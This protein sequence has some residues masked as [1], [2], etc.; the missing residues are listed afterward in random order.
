MSSN[1][2][3][4]GLDFLPVVTNADPFSGG[5][6]GA[7]GLYHVEG[8]PIASIFGKV[9]RTAE[10]EN[11]VGSRVINVTCDGGVGTGSFQRPGGPS[12][13]CDEAPG[14]YLGKGQPSLMVNLSQSWNILQN[15]RA[16]VNIDGMFGHAMSADY[17]AAS[18]TRWT[19]SFV[20]QD[21][22][23]MVAYTS[24]ERTTPVFHKNGFV[25]LR[26]LSLRY[27]LPVGLAGSLG[28]N[29]ASISGLWYNPATLWWEAGETLTERRPHDPEMM[30]PEMNF[31]GV[32]MGS[33]PPLSHFT[34]KVDVAF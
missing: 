3:E 22:P 2:D 28:L 21:D 12:V 29:R 32:N 31:P 16:G 34:V 30:S 15:V 17:L 8:F 25:K 24:V 26:E 4:L 7:R 13:P 20:Y 18:Q 19:R 33:P 14:I 27:S 23:I 10:F 1:I 11:G 9:I 6:E 5:G